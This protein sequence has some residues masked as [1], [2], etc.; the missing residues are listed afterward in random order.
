MGEIDNKHPKRFVPPRLVAF[1]VTAA[2]AA[3]PATFSSVIIYLYIAGIG[4]GFASNVRF[5]AIV[6]VPL[7]PKAL[8]IAAAIGVLLW[9]YNHA[10]SQLPHAAVAFAA[11]CG[12][13]LFGVLAAGGSPHVS[14][15]L[16]AVSALAA[17][18]FVGYV[19]SLISRR[20][21][22]GPA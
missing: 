5:A 18:A 8:V 10:S 3:I 1:T 2:G 17:W 13:A 19:A 7:L 11:A 14:R 20:M 16:A 22:S 4:E 6:T 9:Q 21:G 12:G 15:P